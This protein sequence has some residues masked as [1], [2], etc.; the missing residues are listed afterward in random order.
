MHKTIQYSVVFVTL[1][2]LTSAVMGDA[3]DQTV[4]QI[5]TLEAELEQNRV[6][7]E[8]KQ[9]LIEQ[10][11]STLRENHNLNAPKSQFE[12]DEDYAAR[13]SQLDTIISQRRIELE[14]Q[15]LSGPL[16]RNLEIQPQIVRLYRRIFQT[17]DIT[18]TLGEYNAN[19]EFFPITFE[20]T[21]NGKIQ[22]LNGHLQINKDDA[23]N[24][25][26]NWDEVIVTGWVSIDPGYRRGLAQVKLEYPPLWEQGVTWTADV[27]YDLGNNH[28]VDFSPD[29][30]YLA[31]GNSN[32]ITLW[33]VNTGTPL[34]MKETR[35][36]GTK[37]VAF[38]PNGQYFATGHDDNV[39]VWEVGSGK[40]I[41]RGQNSYSSYGRTYYAD[42]Y[43]VDFSPDG[44]HLA[45]GDTRY[46][47]IWEV[48]S[49]KLVWRGQ[50]S[51]SSY[52]RTYYADFYAVDYRPDGKYLATGDSHDDAIIWEVSSGRRV[53][54]MDHGADV[55][56]VSFNA[57]GRYL[58]TGDANGT[59]S[60][61]EI[62]S[63]QR[64]RQ[65]ELGEAVFI[66]AYSPDGEYLAVGGKDSTITFY[67]IGTE[68]ITIQTKITKA[69][70][71]NTGSAVTDLA[72]QPNGNLISDGKK[73]YRTLL[74]SEEVTLA[75]ATL[76]KILGDNQQ[77]TPGAALANPFVVEVTDQSGSMLAG[78][79]VTFTVTAG[80]GSLS[81]TTATTDTNGR[82]QST[83]ILGSNAGTNTVS[84]SV[85]GSLAITFNAVG[86]V[87]AGSGA[88]LFSSEIA[89]V[90]IGT[91]FTINLTAENITDLAGWQLGVTFNPSVLSA[92]SVDEGDFLKKSGGATFFLEGT[93]D[94]IAGSIANVSGA[95]LGTGGV[96]G[97]GVLLSITFSAKKVGEGSLQLRDVHLGTP[98]GS[99]I[100]YEIT[101]HPV[102]VGNRSPA[103]DVNRDG[104]V[105]VFDLIL[106]AQNFGLSHPTDPGVDVNGDGTINIFDA[107]VVAQHFGEEA[108]PAAPIVE[109]WSSHPPAQIL[110]HLNPKTV[111]QWIDLACIAND[112]SIAF[113]LGIMNLKHLLDVLIP[114]KITLLANYPNPFNPET[115][116]SYELADDADVQ[117]TIYDTKG[118]LVRQFEL[119]HQMA[120]YYTN[121]RR[122]VYWDGKSEMGERVASGIYF[123]HLQVK[124][125]RSNPGAGDFSA[126]RKM[127]IR[128]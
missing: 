9:T 96:S 101:L 103:W 81:T 109:G 119:G 48:S 53:R 12:S 46:L 117:L 86:M 26:D 116:I 100:P 110:A 40:R 6:L 122:A 27:G 20:A 95:Y 8:E 1:V 87:H 43:A 69:K 49:G 124:S 85:V 74:Q 108:V 76:T 78:V 37:G 99:A 56:T 64:L 24:L 7:I 88:K 75:S 79:A 112:G 65:I 33:E 28:S 126:M 128:K 39:T 71:V 44:K 107:I 60:I 2:V 91:T 127:V 84:V 50:N 111:Q 10:Q 118:V 14:E 15:H 89:P 18:A 73:V 22:H 63:G 58:A 83:L 52:G 23:R 31:T 41:W 5:Q 92:V 105:N 125:Y 51:Y 97:T 61:W 36:V 45:T 29:G 19:E 94:N 67:R 72:W 59:V 68:E 66:V 54:R 113:Q 21:L 47:T 38:G 104:Q 106:V 123:Y 34:L 42:F 17:P 115:W 25:S 11:L 90:S 62:S 77:G 4:A 57:D 30:Q 82:V 102:I 55:Y 16:E 13:L 32:S 3:F 80:G 35:S 120:G 93:I 98:S 114:D 70:S 121:R